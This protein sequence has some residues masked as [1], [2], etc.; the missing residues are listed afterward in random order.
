MIESPVVAVRL[1]QTDPDH[2]ADIG[3]AE[4]QATLALLR[5][6]GDG[7]WS[8]PT[9]CTEWDVRTLVAHLVAQCEDS[10]HLGTM[11]RRDLLGRRRSPAKTALDAHSGCTV[12]TWPGRPGSRWS[13]VTTTS[14]SS[15]R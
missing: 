9:D 15:P 10:L 6:L 7:D 1:P 13:S 2:A 11:L 5:A 3:Q 12:S 14:R 8:R 4:G